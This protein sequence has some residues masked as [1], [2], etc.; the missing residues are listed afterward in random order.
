ATFYTNN[1]AG[2]VIGIGYEDGNP[3]VTPPIIFSLDRRGRQTA[4]TNGNSASTF[5][6]NDAGQLLS[7][8][9]FGGI[10]GGLSVTNRY[11]QYLRRTNVA[12]NQSG[13]Q[14]SQQSMAFDPASRLQ[15]VS[16]GI[17]SA[18]Y[19]YLDNS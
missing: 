13:A 1:A 8:S 11:D 16:S 18:T 6:Y 3:P 4:V 9:Y 7:E 15:T 19:T 17:N 10:L 14:L 5:G 2:E 12:V